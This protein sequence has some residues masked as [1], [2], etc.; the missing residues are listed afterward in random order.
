MKVKSTIKPQNEQ[1]L[2][3]IAGELPLPHS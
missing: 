1:N 3:R 2:F